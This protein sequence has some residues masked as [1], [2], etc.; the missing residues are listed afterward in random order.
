VTRCRAPIRRRWPR[1]WPGKHGRK[2][3]AREFRALKR[4]AAQRLARLARVIAASTF[5][6]GTPRE[7]AVDRVTR[8]LL[9]DA[10][11]RSG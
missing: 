3:T 4:R 8:A 2:R 5:W 9:A 10:R 1:S 6:L 7:E 11:R